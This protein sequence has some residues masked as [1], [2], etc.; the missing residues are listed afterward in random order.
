LKAYFHSDCGGS[1]S[2]AEEVWG[3]A[4]SGIGPARDIACEARS[5]GW[6][7]QWTMERLRSRLMSEFVLPADVKLL[8]VVV[9][10]QSGSRRAEWVDLIFSK[11]IFK[12]VRGEDVRRLLGYDKIKSTMFVVQKDV[13]SWTFKGRG[14]GHGVGMCQHGA[15][16][17]AKNGSDFKKILAHYYPGSILENSTLPKVAPQSVALLFE[18]VRPKRV[19]KAAQP[20]DRD[21]R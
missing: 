18:P 9:R 10:E 11:G 17:M 1:T 7:S 6:S 19:A 2:S 20:A 13:G 3:Q 5:S 16:A 14:F 4:G 21:L 15:K 12:R 8:D